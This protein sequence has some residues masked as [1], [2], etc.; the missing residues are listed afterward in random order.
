[1]YKV[2]A[3]LPNITKIYFALVQFITIHYTKLIAQ[4]II[5]NL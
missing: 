4:L 3:Q 1:M 5:L 2:V